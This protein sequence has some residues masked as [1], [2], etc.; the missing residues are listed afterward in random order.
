MSTWKL[1]A[2][3]TT[4]V[5]ASGVY[6]AVRDSSGQFSSSTTAQ[7]VID[8]FGPASVRGKRL[9]VTGC[10]PGGIGY[11]TARVLALAGAT[12]V[13]HGRTEEKSRA[14][15]SLLKREAGLAGS[16]LEPVWFDQAS[17]AQ[18]VSAGRALAAS[19]APLHGA[20][21][22][23]GLACKELQRTEDGFE[24]T[25]GVNHLAPLALFLTLLP[26]LIASG[27]AR[28]AWVS[29]LL[30][31]AGQGRFV[32]RPD[33]WA[34]GTAQ[35]PYSL[36]AAYAEAKL[37]QVIVAQECQRRFGHLGVTSASVH[38]GLIKTNLTE[39][40]RPRADQQ[41]LGDRVGLFVEDN[42]FP[43]KSIAQGAATSVY[44]MAAPDIAGGR[45]YANCRAQ[46]I[47]FDLF[48]VPFPLAARRLALDSAVAT[49]YYDES[50]RL[51]KKWLE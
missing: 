34:R 5:L 26:K 41:T 33:E 45:Y 46:Q 39:G 12:V 1:V 51:I 16:A 11:E 44:V 4:A 23:A 42:F 32:E 7:Q 22:N 2:A 40:I 19:D 24:L 3:A 50:E 48:G 6:L 35:T 28:V 10:T 15:V 27:P 29:S 25:F 17:L 30:H 14:I 49:K 21:L 18:V 31:A 43:H 37:A 20:V 8:E 13:V 9:L 38:P 36:Q 47:G